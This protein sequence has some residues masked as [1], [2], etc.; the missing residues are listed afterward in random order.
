ML[1]KHLFLVSTF[2]G[3]AAVAL[4][5]ASCGTEKWIDTDGLNIGLARVSSIVF[6]LF[7]FENLL[8]VFVRMRVHSYDMVSVRVCVPAAVVYQVAG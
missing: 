5:I 4:F 1:P 8:L 2:L 3:V 6:N 7:R